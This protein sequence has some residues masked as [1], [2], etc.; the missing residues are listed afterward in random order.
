MDQDG[1]SF[2]CEVLAHTNDVRAVCVMDNAI[3]SGS[4][5]MTGKLWAEIRGFYESCATL[6]GHS[7]YISAVCVLGSSPNFPLG[8][9][10]TGSHDNKIFGFLPYTQEPLLALE[11]HSG[12]VCCLSP[13]L[14]TDF[15]LSSSW[16]LSAKIWDVHRRY[17][18]YTIYGHSQT[19]WAVINI[20]GD[21]I[22]TGSADK[23]LQVFGPDLQ[24]THT[25]S[26]HSDCVRGI[27][28][29][30]QTLIISCSNDGTLRT[31]NVKDGDCLSILQVHS[32]YIYSVKA[33][34]DKDLIV[35]GCEDRILI[36]IYK[37]RQ[38]NV[39]LP[40][41]SIWTVDILPNLD[42]V[43]GSSDGYVRIFTN[44]IS[45]QGSATE[46][47]VYKTQLSG[48]MSWSEQVSDADKWLHVEQVYDEGEFDGELKFVT[49]LNKIKCFKW[50]HCDRKW[51]PLENVKNSE[52]NLHV[53]DGHCEGEV[54][55]FHFDVFIEGDVFSP[56]KLPFTI[57]QD[58]SSVA[59]NFVHRYCLNPDFTKIVKEFLERSKKSVEYMETSE[60][61]DKMLEMFSIPETFIFF[62]KFE[63]ETVLERLD[64]Y[65]KMQKQSKTM[66]LQFMKGLLTL[67]NEKLD[68]TLIEYGVRQLITCMNILP[69]GMVYP[70]LDITRIALLRPKVN[71]YIF[72]E[73]QALP[74]FDIFKH[75]MDENCCYNNRMLVCR[76]LCNMFSTVEGINFV[77]AQKGF[78][79]SHLPMSK[80]PEKNKMFEIALSS[81]LLNL[82]VEAVKRNDIVSMTLCFDISESVLMSV[83]EEEAIFRLLVAIG[84]LCLSLN[85]KLYPSRLFDQLKHI[86]TWKNRNTDASHK[87]ARCALFL[88]SQNV[89]LV[90]KRDSGSED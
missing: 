40:A 8:L 19:I 15:L 5:D 1:Y 49:V 16:D 34:F 50:C 61:A 73:G 67:P 89:S 21:Y 48:H 70:V 72:R 11:G 83:K 31:W 12:P 64:H 87:A 54:Y 42:I 25:L 38:Q 35:A 55:D 90:L 81:L 62:K 36:I 80:F 28:Y 9:I 4:R 74:L 66:S 71:A 86:S 2:R 47:E 69:E 77:F 10:L 41:Q 14:K 65:W 58:T 46:V 26:G 85:K 39:V 13:S 68:L 84:K 32:N 43:T 6:K 33:V 59:Q 53:P 44:S 60:I 88:I 45:R 18:V 22:V 24:N 3:V 52:Q 79:F 57:G 20:P 23:T 29:L 82:S 75:F 37:G 56:F 7:N 76:I 63:E 27:A 51:S 17:C 30:H 78:I